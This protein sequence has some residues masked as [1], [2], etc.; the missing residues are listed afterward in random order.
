MATLCPYHYKKVDQTASHIFLHIPL[1]C[2]TFACIPSYDYAMNLNMND[3]NGFC[4]LSYLDSPFHDFYAFEG[5]QTF[6][7]TESSF[8]SSNINDHQ[9]HFHISSSSFHSPNHQ[10]A[11]HQSSYCQEFNDEYRS[12]SYEEL[13]PNDNEKSKSKITSKTRMKWTEELHQKFI[14]CIDQLGGA[15]KATPKQLLHLM[16]TKGLTIIHIKSHLQKYR[17]SQHIQ[18]FSEGKS[19]RQINKSGLMHCNQNLVKQLMEAVRQQLDT[20]RSLNEQLEIQKNLISDI[21]EQMKQLTGVLELR[22]KPIVFRND[23]GD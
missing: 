22:R 8:A 3:Y 20:Q 10:E 6:S 12:W 4:P 7:E 18:E 1:Y 21:E 2:F 5:Y 19:E 11:Q 13:M 9:H 14:N 23:E 16:K 17:I 15:Q